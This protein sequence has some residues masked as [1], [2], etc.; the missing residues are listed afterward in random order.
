MLEFAGV[1]I[2]M[3]ASIESH[4]SQNVSSGWLVLYASVSGV[5]SLIE[6]LNFRTPDRRAESCRSLKLNNGV[7]CIL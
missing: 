6:A 7:A 1:G 5:S 3:T 2:T 4:A